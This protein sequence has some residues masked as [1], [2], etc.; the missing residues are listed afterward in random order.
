MSFL[1][2]VK[3]IVTK[4]VLLKD[5]SSGHFYSLQLPLPAPA[6]F[7]SFGTTSDVGHNRLGQPHNRVLNKV[8]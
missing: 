7:L 5:P 4:T 6:T 3:D 2:V 8:L 1:F